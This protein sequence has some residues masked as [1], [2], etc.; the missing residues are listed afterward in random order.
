MPQTNM[1][2]ATASDLTNA[3]TDYSVDS[4]TLDSAGDQNETEWTNYVNSGEEIELKH[5]WYANGQ[6]LIKAKAIDIHGKEG[7]WAE[8]PI[9]MSKNKAVTGNMLL[10]KILERFPILQRL[11]EV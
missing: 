11:L 4:G 6:Y 3:V 8:F 7:G 10:L 5:T 1:R 9:S 2:N